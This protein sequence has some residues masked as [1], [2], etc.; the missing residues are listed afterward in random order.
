MPHQV[1]QPR[2]RVLGH[3]LPPGLPSGL[4]LLPP[5]PVPPLEVC[6]AQMAQERAPAAIE[7]GVDVSKC[8]GTMTVAKE[9][10]TVVTATVGA[11]GLRQAGLSAIPLPLF[12]TLPLQT[13]HPCFSWKI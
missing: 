9:E 7:I 3:P 5:T 2:K 13:R 6:L 12:Q 10:P 8:Q 1:C 4:E 11:S